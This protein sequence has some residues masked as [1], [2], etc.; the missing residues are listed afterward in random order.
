MT[1]YFWFQ[2]IL[3]ILF[4]QRGWLKLIQNLTN[5]CIQQTLNLL[6]HKIWG[7][8]LANDTCFIISFVDFFFATIE[9][10]KTANQYVVVQNIVMPAEGWKVTGSR[11]DHVYCPVSSGSAL[12]RSCQETTSFMRFKSGL[13]VRH[14]RG[15]QTWSWS[16]DLTFYSH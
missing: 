3:M 2:F 16:Y 8:I 1:L 7:W 14:A 5:I 12:C 11:I 9:T 6:I 15:R 4:I 13:I 10:R